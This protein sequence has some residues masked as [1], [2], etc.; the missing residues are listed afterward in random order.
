MTRTPRSRKCRP[1][2]E[3]VRSL[4]QPRVAWVMVP[5]GGATQA[6][7][8]ELAAYMAVG[9]IIIDGG[10]SY[11][12]D[13]MKRS[14]ALKPKG[15]AFMDVGTS[16]GIWG[17]TEGFSLMAGGDPEVYKRIEPLLQALAPSAT[18]GYG[19]MGPSGAGH[20]VKMVHNGI[21]YGLMQAYAEGFELMAAKSE[22]KLDLAPDFAG[23]A[24]RQRRA[25]LAARPRR[26]R[27]RRRPRDDSPRGVR[28]RLRRRT[29]D[30]AGVDRAG[31]ARA[32]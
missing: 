12:K 21:E 14:A 17:L 22:F 20:F 31:R 10:N 11:Y 29:L 1:L 25:L 32:R 3:L 27:S 13:S 16:G 24:G 7:V 2:E 6:T 26:A 4:P 8:E 5:A 15:I 18:S 30:R 28:R 23:M 9:D 19:H